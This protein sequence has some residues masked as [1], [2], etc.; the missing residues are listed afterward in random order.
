VVALRFFGVDAAWQHCPLN[1][2]RA[3]D[4]T[5][6]TLY[7]ELLLFLIHIDV[8]IRAF[9]CWK[10]DL[11]A[12]GIQFVD[13]LR[14]TNRSPRNYIHANQTSMLL[15]STSQL[16]LGGST[17]IQHNNQ[18]RSVAPGLWPATSLRLSA[19]NHLIVAVAVV[20]VGSIVD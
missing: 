19:A 16:I 13:G 4:P 15:G 10:D 8:S 2:V 17:T 7:V 18:C 20:L 1:R 5:T 11:I 3:E 12:A 14:Y 6:P 9:V